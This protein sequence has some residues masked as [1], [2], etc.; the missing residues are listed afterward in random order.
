[1][2]YKVLATREPREVA[3]RP[4]GASSS[5]VG[6]S[7]GD[8]SAYCPRNHPAGRGKSTESGPPGVVYGQTL[9]STCCR[10]GP[11]HHCQAFPCMS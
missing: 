9:H 3:V 5:R 11:A 10:T 4:I 8:T 7:G 1:M 2:I 6:R